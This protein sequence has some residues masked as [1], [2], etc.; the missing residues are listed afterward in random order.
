ML[1]PC[2]ADGQ[3]GRA[4]KECAVIVIVTELCHYFCRKKISVRIQR[5]PDENLGWTFREKITYAS[6]KM[7]KEG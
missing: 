5:L 4:V 7:Y 1:L 2:P 3:I 6:V